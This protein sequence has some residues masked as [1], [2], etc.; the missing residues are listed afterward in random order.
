MVESVKKTGRK[1]ST[2]QSR[3]SAGFKRKQKENHDKRMENSKYAERRR[4]LW[5]EASARY[6]AKPGNREKRK[7]YLAKPETQKMLKAYSKTPEYRERAR[8]YQRERYR[9]LKAMKN[10][11]TI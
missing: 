1:V 6:R 11:K 3:P 8:R 7:A 2:T 4:K 9:R 5:R 10:K